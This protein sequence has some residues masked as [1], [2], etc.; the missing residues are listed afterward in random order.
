M[1]Q[2]IDCPPSERVTR[3]TVDFAAIKAKQ[4]AVWGSGDYAVIGT[5]LQIVGESLCEALNLAAGS[6][7][8]DVA[9]GNGNGTL[10]AARRFCQV[11]GVDYVSSLLERG[12]ERARAERLAIDFV[13]ADA[14]QLPFD[15]ASFDV[16]LSVFGVMFSP[17]QERAARELVRV[18]RPGGNIGLA[19]WTPDGFVGKMLRIVTSY[20]PAPA[21]VGA[22]TYW[23]T[24][25]RLTELFPSVRSISSRRTTF[26]FR[27]ASPEHFVDVFR[28]FYGPT[29][30]AFGALAPNQQTNLADDLAQLVSEC[31][32]PVGRSL[33]IHSPYLETVIER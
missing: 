19:S 3:P 32:R 31:A 23:G 5:T 30:K 29:F 6:R 11:T 15:D 7:V 17:D 8:L 33:V 12:A 28:N 18:V 4:R 22:P 21:G 25:T 9:C 26:A 14:E 16:A 24:D 1:T 10:A 2:I 27:Y 13:E 20:V